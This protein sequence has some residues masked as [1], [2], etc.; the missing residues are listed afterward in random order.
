MRVSGSSAVVAVATAG[1]RGGRDGTHANRG[2]ALVVITRH[3]RAGTG[4]GLIP[5]PRGWQ[6][7]AQSG[8]LMSPG[9]L[10]IGLQV[11]RPVTSTVAIATPAPVH[12]RAETVA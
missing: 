5:A 12:H 3:H 6:L 10:R 7:N 4:D 1:R 11:G 9:G 8:R 2:S